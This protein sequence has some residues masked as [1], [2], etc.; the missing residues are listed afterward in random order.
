MDGSATT[1]NDRLHLPCHVKLE[2]FQTQNMCY[3]PGEYHEILIKKLQP[4]QIITTIYFL[5]GLNELLCASNLNRV[6]YLVSLK[7]KQQ[8]VLKY[9]YQKW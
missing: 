4:R 5:L 3:F 1:D 7:L 9:V 6:V 8:S 2:L